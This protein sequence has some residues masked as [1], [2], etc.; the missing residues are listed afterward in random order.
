MPDLELVGALTISWQGDAALG[1]AAAGQCGVSGSLEILPGSGPAN[2]AGHATLELT[3]TDSAA[4]VIKRSA[5]GVVQ[6]ACADLVPTDFFLTL[7]RS[8]GG[9]LR[10]VLDR[11]LSLQLPSAGRC[12]GPTAGD[13]VALTLPARRVGRGG[14]DLSGRTRLASGPF[15]V[16]ATSSLRVVDRGTVVSFSGS[17]SVVPPGGRSRSRSSY[18]VEH[19]EAAY[20]VASV[21][22]TLTTSFAGLAPPLC[23][24]LGACGSVGALSET[25]SGTGTIRVSGSR[26]VRR[27]VGPRA[28]LS[29][30][31][32]GRLGAGFVG[33]E[34]QETVS[35]S[36]A[37]PNGA[38]CA[39]REVSPTPLGTPS[40]PS[41]PPLTLGPDAAEETPGISDPLRT[42][43]PGPTGA[44]VLGSAPLAIGSVD[45][46]PGAP[47]MTVTFTGPGS[48]LAG[49]YT[50]E[51][52][53]SL[54]MTLALEHES[55]GTSR[56]RVPR[57]R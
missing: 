33:T 8:S 3:D 35:E 7:R 13:L 39:D 14:Y 20:R 19:A 55:G 48:F 16:T 45:G 17:V 24:P 28:A 25:I 22:G 42:R 9:P 18:L 27:R 2:S 47:A 40:F 46:D 52:G 57:A 15:A 11:D 4:R 5:N 32:A 54:V 50:G 10:A 37:G 6:G 44:D 21:T 36:L 1:C 49:A 53:G 29:D 56:V 41:S 31:R 30:F 34:I 43:C 12:A 26:V 38:A 51:R 23:V